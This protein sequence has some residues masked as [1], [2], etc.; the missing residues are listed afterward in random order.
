MGWQMWVGAIGGL[1]AVVGQ[2]W[3]AEWYLPLIGG[4][5]ALIAVFTK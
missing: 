3:G 5:L 4:I 2:F 1:A